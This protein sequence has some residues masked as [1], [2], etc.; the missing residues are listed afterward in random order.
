MKIQVH[1]EWGD[2]CSH[3]YCGWDNKYPCLGWLVTNQCQGCHK[4]VTGKIP[5]FPPANTTLIIIIKPSINAY[6]LRI[7][8][9]ILWS[10]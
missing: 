3:R 9:N 10:V 4:A 6:Q 8:F 2:S 5:L 1:M 7:C